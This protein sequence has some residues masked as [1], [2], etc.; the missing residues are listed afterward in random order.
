MFNIKLHIIILGPPAVGKL[1]VGK[2]LSQLIDFPLFDNA[3]TVDLAAL[4]HDYDTNE[5]RI[6]RDHLRNSF[7]RETVSNSKINGLISTNV[8]RHPINWKYFDKVENIFSNAGWETKYIM[9][10]ASEEELLNRV[11]SESRKSK[12]TLTSE[13]S[14]RKWIFDNPL[15]TSLENH[16]CPIINTTNISI[17]EVVGKINLVINI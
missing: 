14:L 10:T 5:F 13:E 15:H 3:K 1:T 11:V 12:Y 17:E 8:L 9:L 6:Y 16:T 7:Y 2:V 4:I